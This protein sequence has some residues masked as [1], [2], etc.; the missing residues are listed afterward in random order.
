MDEQ[1]HFHLTFPDLPNGESEDSVQL[2][3]GN[4]YCCPPSVEVYGEEGVQV[5][6]FSKF[7]I[8]GLEMHG[9]Y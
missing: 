4:R 1:R 9:L 5:F 8:D 2:V 6:D 3:L 7:Y